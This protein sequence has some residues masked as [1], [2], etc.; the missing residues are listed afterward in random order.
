[1]RG[2]VLDVSA[3]RRSEL[4][5]RQV[6]GQLAHVARVAMLGQLAAAL[7]HELGEPLGAILRNAEAAELSPHEPPDLDELRAILADIARTAQRAGDV[8]ERLV[9][10]T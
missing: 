9:R 2:V 1:M 4:E 7:A 5:L 6:R 3:R 10:A 8:I